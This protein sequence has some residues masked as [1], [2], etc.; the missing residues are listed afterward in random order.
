MRILETSSTSERV[1]MELSA[2]EI[3]TITWALHTFLAETP[4]LY[5][6]LRDDIQE[7]HECFD[8]IGTYRAISD[9]VAE[10][11]EGE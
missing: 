3:D 6:R 2:T 11:G 4:P 10:P 5:S 7:L 9:I 1:V 8:C